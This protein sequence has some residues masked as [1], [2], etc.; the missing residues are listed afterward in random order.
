VH[1]DEK[2][3]LL[4]GSELKLAEAVTRADVISIGVIVNLG[5]PSVRRIGQITYPDA[6][7]RF[8]KFLKGA[9]EK[10]VTMHLFATVGPGGNEDENLKEESESLLSK[11][12]AI[13][14]DRG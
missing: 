2:A 13:V 1:A 5:S 3:P 12:D 9:S 8:T 10:I 14:S 4:P 7:F 11:L 6:Q